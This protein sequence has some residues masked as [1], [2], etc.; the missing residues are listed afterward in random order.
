MRYPPKK[1]VTQRAIAAIH[2]FYAPA[3]GKEA[4]EIPK[5]R[6][7]SRDLE[8]KSQAAACQWW[9]YECKRYG[10]PEFSLFAVPAGGH[11]HMLTAVRLK[12]EGVRRGIPDMMLAVVR[13]P[14]AG[15]F[16]EGKTEEGRVSD[17][18]KEVMAYLVKAGYRCEVPRSTVDYMTYIQDYLGAK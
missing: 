3:F 18:Q 2:S 6:A 11:R 8:H 10:L 12:A 4:P 7:P 15:L 17:E 13:A 5:P 9:R 1:P 14:Y 16:L